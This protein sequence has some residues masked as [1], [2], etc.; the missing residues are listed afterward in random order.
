WWNQY[1]VANQPSMLEGLFSVRVLCGQMFECH[2]VIV[3]CHVMSKML[4]DSGKQVPNQ[5]TLL[6]T[7][8]RMLYLDEPSFELRVARKAFTQFLN[9]RLD[10]LVSLVLRRRTFEFPRRKGE[11]QPGASSS[12]LS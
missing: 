9:E 1:Q 10:N 5:L 12:A 2:P 7:F 11:H 6:R 8:F 3:D 4:V